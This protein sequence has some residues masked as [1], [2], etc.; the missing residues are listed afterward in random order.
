MVADTQRGGEAGL[1]S[2]G[3]NR[4]RALMSKSFDDLPDIKSQRGRIGKEPPIADV[5]SDITELLENYTSGLTTADKIDDYMYAGSK[6]MED[7]GNSLNSG[8]KIEDAIKSSYKDHKY[9]DLPLENGAI[10]PSL[11]D[12][13]VEIFNKN[14]QRPSEY[15]EAKPIRAVSFDEFEGAIVTPNTNQEVIDIL[16]RRGLKVVVNNIEKD[17]GKIEARK[18]FQKQMFSIAPLAAAATVIANQSDEQMDR[19]GL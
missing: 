17:F 16:K 15:F 3:P 19:L 4:L 9:L 18:Q 1:G 5:E 8:I 2:F 12:D 14:A 7:I 6:L 11:L 13:M 10:P